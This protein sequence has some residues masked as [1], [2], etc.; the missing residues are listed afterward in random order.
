MEARA[1]LPW[2][3]MLDYG[4]AHD[5][6]VFDACREPTHLKDRARN[7][8]LLV[9]LEGL[10]ERKEAERAAPS[11]TCPAV[12]VQP[13]A[14]S[15]ARAA[16]SPV[17]PTA[18]RDNV[19]D[20][21]ELSSSSADDGSAAVISRQ[22]SSELGTDDMD[23]LLLSDSHSEQDESSPSRRVWPGTRS[24]CSNLLVE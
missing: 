1:R 24:S 2:K 20:L 14:G 5:H 10:L 13:E 11:A 4:N 23:D 15:D 19:I 12:V 17:V 21:V 16:S 18:A 9:T 22:I 8:G 3:E 7:L 6:G